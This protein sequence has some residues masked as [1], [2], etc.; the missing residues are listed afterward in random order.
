MRPEG[1]ITRAEAATVFFRLLNDSVRDAYRTSENSFRDVKSSDWFNTAVSTMAA[2]GIVEGYPDGTFKP[3]GTV[4]RAEFAAMAARFDPD[5]DATATAFAE[6]YE[7]WGRKE[8]NVSANNGWILG[9]EDGTFKPDE[10][11]TRA[12]AV[13]ML[14]RVLQRIPQ[15]K[16]DLLPGMITWP[17]NADPAAWYYLPVQEASNSHDCRRKENGYEEWT[18]LQEPRKWSE[19]EK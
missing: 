15:S 17:D 1:T 10:T 12:E 9:Y 2:M 13:A 11:I 6:I 8:I 18:R 5:G 3:N 7:H 19:L 14:N 4:T 16:D